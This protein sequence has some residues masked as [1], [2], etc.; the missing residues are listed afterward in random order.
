MI[1]NVNEL[2]EKIKKDLK[3]TI[4]NKEPIISL[5]RVGKEK[6]SISFEKSI[7]K[8]ANG[9][10]MKYISK[11]F[12]TKSSR[13]DIL[14]YLETQN[15]DKNVDGIL[16]FS[17]MEVDFV[18][19]LVFNHINPNKDIDGL[20]NN[21]L[22]N[23]FLGDD[24]VNLPTTATATLEYLKSI[25]DLKGKD[26]LIINRSIIVGKPLALMLTNEDATVTLTHSKTK[27]LNKKI[28]NSDIII[29]AVG[30]G[31]Q[32]KNLSYK[33]GTIIIDLGMNF[34]NGK[35]YGDFDKEEFID[36]KDV[37]YLP[38]LGT[39]GRLSSLLMLRNT[40]LNYE[41]AK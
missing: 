14:K 28:K 33:K 25:T 37:N 1:L 23:L 21:N 41:K 5:I 30:N 6:S 36:N 7:I 15:N 19:M 3:E 8:E 17:P 32:F 38:T 11:V 31:K 35:I 16:I 12:E 27:N 40:Y 4:D 18:E 9:L 24:Y 39:I 10:N 2:Y 22:K 26:I 13:E 34:D 29:S 20:A